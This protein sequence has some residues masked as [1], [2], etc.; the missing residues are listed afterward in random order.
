MGLVGWFAAGEVP[1][2]LV[3]GGAHLALP[4]AA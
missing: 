1:F 3:A 4:N 2:W